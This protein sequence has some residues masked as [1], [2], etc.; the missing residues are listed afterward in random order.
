M[1]RSLQRFEWVDNA[2]GIGIVLIVYLHVIN[3]LDAAFYGRVTENQFWGYSQSLIRTFHM[4]LFFF[5][6]G[7]FVNT[8]ISKYGNKSFDLVK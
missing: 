2:K 6:S 4:P 3:G 8:S 1:N 5:L 7:L